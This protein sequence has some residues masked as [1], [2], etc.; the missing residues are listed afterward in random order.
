VVGANVRARAA[1][2][3]AMGDVPTAVIAAA[4][5]LS[6]AV[7]GAR[8]RARGAGT[9]AKGGAAA[10]VSIWC[11]GVAIGARI[12]PRGS[13]GFVRGT[14]I[15]AWGFASVRLTV[16]AFAAGIR[17]RGS[18]E[19]VRGEVTGA[20]AFTWWLIEAVSGATFRLS[21]AVGVVRSELTGALDVTFWLS[22]TSPVV[23]ASAPPL[24]AP[25]LGLPLPMGA[26]LRGS[27]SSGAAPVVVVRSTSCVTGVVGPAKAWV[28]EGASGVPVGVPDSAEAEEDVLTTGDFGRTALTAG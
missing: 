1:V 21:G 9:A 25:V 14:V 16:E 26:E 23:S 28:A 3:T 20:A 11:I 18:V 13:A 10:A 24:A 5:W 17:P 4:S 27:P 15:E 8:L 22:G 7:T 19:P 2:A 12:R 6:G